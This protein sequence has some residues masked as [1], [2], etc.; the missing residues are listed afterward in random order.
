MAERLS[1]SLTRLANNSKILEDKILKARK[2]SEE[3]LLKRLESSKA[4][5]QLK[6]SNFISRADQVK[7]QGES[8]M[9]SFQISIRHKVSHLKAE[10]EENRIFFDNKSDQKEDELNIASA[11]QYYNTSV[12]IAEFAIE[13]ALIA[14]AEVETA[15]MEAYTAKLH[16]EKVMEQ[17]K[18]N[19]SL[20]NLK[21]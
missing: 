5:L 11:E 16:V 7:A 19:Y 1:E 8:E 9:N 15:I 2:D 17:V 4:E 20:S 3:S 14:L 10:A 13:L 18:E 6:K 21:P 12:D